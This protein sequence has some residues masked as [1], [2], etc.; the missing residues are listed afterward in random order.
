MKT[1]KIDGLILQTLYRNPGMDITEI[2][3]KSE[4]SKNVLKYRLHRLENVGF[5]SRSRHG[6]KRINQITLTGVGALESLD[7]MTT[8]EFADIV[9]ADVSYNAAVGDENWFL[10]P[11]EKIV[12]GKQQ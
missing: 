9:A 7:Y 4:I 11:E 8:V 12:A 3:K 2:S 5:I 10:K 6:E 1:V